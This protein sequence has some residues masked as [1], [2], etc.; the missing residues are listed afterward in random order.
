MVLLEIVLLFAI[1]FLFVITDSRTVTI[2][3]E[4]TL[5]STKFTYKSIRGNL[6]EGLKVRELSYN[7]HK[8]FHKATIHW[9]PIGLL[10]HKVSLTRVE[11]EGLEL[12]SV[13]GMVN[14]LEMT[15]SS[16]K[17]KKSSSFDYT[18]SLNNIHVDINPYI[19]EGVKFSS[20][21]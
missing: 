14:E 4:Q 2:L 19:F 15:T 20:F 12:D 5:P 3:A 21:I 18:L 11:V 9:N 7:N 10:Y 8:L 16:G 6:F 17:G 1:L 13:M